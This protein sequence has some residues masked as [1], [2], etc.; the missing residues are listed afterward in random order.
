MNARPSDV[1]A[2]NEVGRAKLHRAL[3]MGILKAQGL[4][5]LASEELITQAIAEGRGLALVRHLEA[6]KRDGGRT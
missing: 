1:A 4:V 2:L 6:L 3:L 5:G